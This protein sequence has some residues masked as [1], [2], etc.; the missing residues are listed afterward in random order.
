MKPAKVAGIAVA[1][2]IGGLLIM[3]VV[4]VFVVFITR[5]GKTKQPQVN[6]K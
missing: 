2:V 1:A 4:I 6:T 3:A 5:C